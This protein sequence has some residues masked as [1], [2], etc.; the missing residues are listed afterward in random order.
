MSRR[1]AS[2]LITGWTLG[3][4]GREFGPTKSDAGRA[5]GAGEVADCKALPNDHYPPICDGAVGRSRRRLSTDCVE[6][7]GRGGFVSNV[8]IY[9]PRSVSIHC[10]L[11]RHRESFFRPIVAGVLFQQN[12]PIDDVRADLPAMAKKVLVNCHG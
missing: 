6:T 1:R 10:H 2:W 9:V 3:C 4:V 8:P 12:Q 7:V 11:A 5:G